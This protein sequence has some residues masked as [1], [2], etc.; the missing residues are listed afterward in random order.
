SS[1]LSDNE[2]KLSLQM[3]E[4][5]RKM[6]EMENEYRA[7]QAKTPLLAFLGNGFDYLIQRLWC[8]L[9]DEVRVPQA[10]VHAQMLRDKFKALQDALSERNFPDEAKSLNIVFT[11]I[12]LLEVILAQAVHTQ[13]DQDRFDLIY[14][15]LEK[16]VREI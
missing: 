15:G 6:D 4:I 11:G 5:E 2:T 13:P 8:D 14:D 3:R 12:G 16:R 9:A 10:Q 7:E 1:M